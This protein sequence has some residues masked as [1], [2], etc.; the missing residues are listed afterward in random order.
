MSF[1]LLFAAVS[2]SESIFKLKTES[3]L[4]SS[5]EVHPVSATPGKTMV[6]ITFDWNKIA[7]D[8][9]RKWNW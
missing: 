6:V 3:P 1:L 4:N 5:Q 8:F 2:R 7:K 9:K